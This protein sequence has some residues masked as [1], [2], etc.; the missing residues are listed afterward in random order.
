MKPSTEA[1]R[2]VQNDR[3]LSRTGSPIYKRATYPNLYCIKANHFW[4]HQNPWRQSNIPFT[5]ATMMDRQFDW[6]PN[7]STENHTFPSKLS[8]QFGF[9]FDR[10]RHHLKATFMFLSAH[11]FFFFGFHLFGRTQRLVDTSIDT[12]SLIAMREFSNCCMK[13]L[14]KSMQNSHCAMLPFR[15]WMNSAN[16]VDR[17]N[18]SHAMHEHFQQLVKDRH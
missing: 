5:I 18:I 8:M 12:L 9:T 17:M 10:Q 1:A 2:R 13:F 16:K 15:W 6:L 7:N 4:I 3:K 11:I 14:E